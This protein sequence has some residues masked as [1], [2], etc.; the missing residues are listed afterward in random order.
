MAKNYFGAPTAPERIVVVGGHGFIGSAIVSAARGREFNVQPLGRSEVDLLSPDAGT[1]LRDQLRPKDTVV[2][3][4]ARA[5]CKDYSEFEQNILMVKNA[6]DGLVGLP[7]FQF[8]YISSDAV[9][10][11]SKSPLKETSVAAPDSLHGQ[12]HIA[13]EAMFS[14]TL[15]D[16]PISILRPTLVFGGLDPHNGYGP[17]QFRRKAQ[18]GEMISIFGNGEELRDHVF[19]EDVA[20]LAMRMIEHRTTGILNAATGRVVSFLELAEKTVEISGE[21]IEIEHRTRMGPMPHDGYRAF[22]AS[23]V[24]RLYPQFKFVELELGLETSYKDSR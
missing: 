2:F 18:A 19:V 10:T 3:I 24:A 14:K 7:L 22:D 21:K 4:S 5:P 9:Y 1:S 23:E 15:V 17:N 11:D 16:I 6:L 13:R 12:M 20:E 8:L